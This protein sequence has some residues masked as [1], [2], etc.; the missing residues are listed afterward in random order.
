[1][2]PIRVRVQCETNLWKAQRNL[3]GMS[4]CGWVDGMGWFPMTLRFRL[5]GSKTQEG[6]L[7]LAHKPIAFHSVMGLCSSWWCFLFLGCKWSE[8]DS[9]P[10]HHRDPNTYTIS[11]HAL[12]RSRRAYFYGCHIWHQRCEVLLIHIDGVW[13]SLHM[14]VS[15]LGYHELANM[16]RLGGV[17]ECPT[18]KASPHMLHWKPPCF[19]VDDA[20]QEL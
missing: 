6:H 1:M 3:V 13:F 2:D 20:P 14:N 17:V 5:L 12:I 8:W 11:G 19:I 7:A 15:C 10:F 18:S 16:W 9:C 4:E